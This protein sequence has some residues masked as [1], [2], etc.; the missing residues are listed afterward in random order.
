MNAL[1]TFIGKYLAESK[2][3]PD[4]LALRSGLSRASVF[5]A[6]QGKD[7]RLSGIQKIV[8]AV[9]EPLVIKPDIEAKCKDV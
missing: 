8:N 3:S 4:G 1:S 9:G 2:E 7:L 6:K 5:R